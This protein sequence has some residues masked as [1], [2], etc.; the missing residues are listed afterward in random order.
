MRSSCGQSLYNE[1]V[2]II[3]TKVWRIWR[4][5]VRIC[6][7]VSPNRSLKIF[8]KLYDCYAVLPT[9]SLAKL[10]YSCITYITASRQYHHKP[11][12]VVLARQAIPIDARIGAAGQAMSQ[13]MQ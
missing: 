8:A 2:L 11:A 10:S 4:H 3:A 7:S 1:T 6:I 5:T 9:L 13:A 12:T